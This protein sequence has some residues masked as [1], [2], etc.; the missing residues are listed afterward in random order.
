MARALMHQQAINKV[1]TDKDK[2][3]L[4]WRHSLNRHVKQRQQC[5][6]CTHFY[7]I[8]LIKDRQKQN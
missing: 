4:Q 8:D 7:F 1:M 3:H 6:H 5:F 2:E